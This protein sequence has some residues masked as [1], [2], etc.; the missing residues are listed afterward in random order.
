MD[1]LTDDRLKDLSCSDHVF[2]AKD[3]I[4]SMVDELISRRQADARWK[5]IET[6]ENMM[7]LGQR[8]EDLDWL[9]G[10]LMNVAFYD[11]PGCNEAHMVACQVVIR[12]IK[13]PSTLKEMLVEEEIELTRAYDC[14]KAY[15]PA[16][17]DRFSKEVSL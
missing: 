3:E 2:L 12:L 8:V 17:L 10:E 5:K 14:V 9:V 13:S 4:R 11:P 16:F 15:A 1:K 7:N 6:L